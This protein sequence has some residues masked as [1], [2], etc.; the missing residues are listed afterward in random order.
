MK[1]T[2]SEKFN[3]GP[4]YVY[5]ILCENNS[6]YTGIC[7]DLE[8]RFKTHLSGKGAKYMRI[9]KPLHFVYIEEYPIHL[10]A[11]KREQ[12]IKSLSCKKKKELCNKIVT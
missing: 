8:K 9:Y 10:S 5:I 11:F 6:L 2:A 7:K 4:W 3:L 12:E 1:M